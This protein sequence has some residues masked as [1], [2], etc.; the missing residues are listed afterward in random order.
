MFWNEHWLENFRVSGTL[1]NWDFQYKEI[2][3]KWAETA[4][5]ILQAF[6]SER[7]ME[8]SLI[9]GMLINMRFPRRRMVWNGHFDFAILEEAFQDA[10]LLKRSR[11]G[12]E[13]VNLGRTT[14]IFIFWGCIG[15]SSFFSLRLGTKRLNDL[16]WTR[17]IWRENATWQ[18][19][20]WKCPR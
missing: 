11:T 4:I 14:K 2:V 5:F 19:L 15:N 3:I 20:I 12:G 7:W 13:L 17:V 8:M 9:S 16:V 6:P 10:L 1:F 18:T